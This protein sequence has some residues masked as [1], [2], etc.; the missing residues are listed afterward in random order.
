MSKVALYMPLLTIESGR[1]VL[2]A[3]S[4]RVQICCLRT[5]LNKDHLL[6]GYTVNKKRLLEQNTRLKELQKT[7]EVMGRVA[8]DGV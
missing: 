1:R 2:M 5:C 4:D 8:L 3:S 6:R 7:V